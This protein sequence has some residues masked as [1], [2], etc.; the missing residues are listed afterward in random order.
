MGCNKSKVLEVRDCV[1]LIRNDHTGIEV[2]LWARGI[3]DR[4]AEAIAAAL[5]ENETLQELYLFNNKIGDRGATALAKALEVNTTL[6][7]LDLHNNPCGEVA[8]A[9]F[10]AVLQI[11]STLESLTLPLAKV[12]AGMRT[13]LQELTSEGWRH[14]RCAEFFDPEPDSNPVSE[15]MLVE[16]EEESF[17]WKSPEER[18]WEPTDVP[19]EDLHHGA[20]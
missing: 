14:Q 11:N 8:A 4:G 5:T 9:A 13:E 2:N 7:R 10:I 18:T 16:I 12:P 20:L 19:S 6:K 3:N 17:G 15:D 1:N